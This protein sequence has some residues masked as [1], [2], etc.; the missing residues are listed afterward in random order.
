MLGTLLTLPASGPLSGVFWIARRIAAIV[1]EEQSD[2]ARVE[3][4]L[5][6]LERRLEAGEID[7]A[8]YDAAEAPLLE[9]LQALRAA[10]RARQ[11]GGA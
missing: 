9:E 8:T 4:A 10:R 5:L 2:P 6:A 11:G 3:A 7:E 1:E